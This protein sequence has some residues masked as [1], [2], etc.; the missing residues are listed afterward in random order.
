MGQSNPLEKVDAAVGAAAAGH[1]V[2]ARMAMVVR[3]AQ[4]AVWARLGRGLDQVVR[5]RAVRGPL[6]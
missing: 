4:T 6:V 5:G 1:D 2:M 3:D